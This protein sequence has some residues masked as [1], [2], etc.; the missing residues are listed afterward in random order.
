MGGGVG[1]DEDPADDPKAQLVDAKEMNPEEK[2]KK[3]AED[4]ARLNKL[5]DFKVLA[6]MCMCVFIK[7]HVT[8]HSGPVTLVILCRSH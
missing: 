4:Q 2:K 1:E 3:D 5:Q 7:L 6:F 8:A